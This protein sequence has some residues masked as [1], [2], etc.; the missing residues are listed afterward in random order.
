M[1]REV[2]LPKNQLRFSQTTMEQYYLD[3]SNLKHLQQVATDFFY[4]TQ[5]CVSTFCTLC[6]PSWHTPLRAVLSSQRIFY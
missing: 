3:K 6:S 2:T 5:I 1:T 4:L